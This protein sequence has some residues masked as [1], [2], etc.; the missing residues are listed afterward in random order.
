M[1][2]RHLIP[3]FSSGRILLTALLL[4][5]TLQGAQAA[6]ANDPVVLRFATVGDSRLDPAYT[7]PAHGALS[8]EEYLWLQNAT[9]WSRLMQEIR[10]KRAN[11]LF[12]NGDM[13]MGYGNAS[14]ERVNTASADAVLNSDLVRYH[15]QAS[16]WRG[17]VATLMASGTYVLP[18][19]GN[20]ETQCKSGTTTTPARLVRHVDQSQVW[21]QVQCADLDGRPVKGKLAM[22]ANEAA[23]RRAFGDLI[24]DE[25]RMNAALPAG[26]TVS[27]IRLTPPGADDGLRTDQTR[28]SYSFDVGR[29]HFAVINTDPA[30][31][32]SSAPVQ[33]LTQDLAAARARGA[34][35]VFVFGH[36]PAFSYLYGPGV[37]P[38]GLDSRTE[39]DPHARQRDAFWALIEAYGATYFCGHE[40]TF[41]MSRPLVK[42]ADGRQ[43]PSRSWQIL[44]GSGGSPFEMSTLAPGQPATDRYHAF[45]LVSVHRSGTVRI[46]AWGFDAQ[47]G[48]T[49]RLG[50]I[51]LPTPR[52]PR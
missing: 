26:L 31:A 32:D 22:P 15:L 48:P 47:R 39:D 9:V 27:A 25:A 42:E 5:P 38:V 36:K 17:M 18:V 21:A 28:L 35:R 23:W 34:R 44:V 19:A 24:I 3:P 51:T 40:H 16:Y 50:A 49:R 29:D 46:E 8:Q 13:I 1:R 2:T 43:R 12:F 7:D 4:W 52:Q 14:A 41:H 10:Q 45:A 20:H 37:Q 33:W 6:A 11:L 30:G